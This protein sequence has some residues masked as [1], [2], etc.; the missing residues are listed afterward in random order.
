MAGKLTL[1]GVTKEVHIAIEKIGEGADPW[2]GYRVGFEG[3]LNFNRK[4][5]SIDYDLGLQSWDVEL[6]L[7]I[8]GIR[9]K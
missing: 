3:K 2:G 7:Y 4:D 9:N 8:E 1:H 5:V 6:S